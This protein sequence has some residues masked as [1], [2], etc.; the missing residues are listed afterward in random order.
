MRQILERRRVE[1][2]QGVQEWRDSDTRKPTSDGGLKPAGQ[3]A[4]PLFGRE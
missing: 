1:F 3:P 2:G 4:P